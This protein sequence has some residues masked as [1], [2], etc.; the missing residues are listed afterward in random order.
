M[1][2]AVHRYFGL[3]LSL[4]PLAVQAQPT[5]GSPPYT[6]ATPQ[7]SQ[8]EPRLRDEDWPKPATVPAPSQR[9]RSGSLPPVQT[10]P[11]LATGPLEVEI[12]SIGDA[13]Y[14]E[15]G[16]AEYLATYRGPRLL[17]IQGVETLLRF[18]HAEGT[19]SSDWTISLS[20]VA[21]TVFR[22]ECNQGKAAFDFTEMPVRSASVVGQNAEIEMTFRRPNTISLDRFDAAILGGKF[23]LGG[24]CNANPRQVTLNLSNAECKLDFTGEVFAG[25]AE[26]L[27][28]GQ[29]KSLDI[30]L[31]RAAGLWVEGSPRTLSYFDSM[32]LVRRRVGD[33]FALVSAGYETG[34]CRLRLRFA[35]EMTP[36]LK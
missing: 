16:T 32:N 35:Q 1:K 15:R 25:E 4:A 33:G 29:P 31:P 6:P 22:I 17:S 3:L 34:A 27:L 12:N 20:P 5:P 10:V 28:D 9:V 11:V 18:S 30:T 26:V 7:R 21:P 36:T 23:V 14:V 2:R 8:S 19:D 24:I 13:V